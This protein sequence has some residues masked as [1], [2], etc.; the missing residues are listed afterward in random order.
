MNIVELIA[1]IFGVLSILFSIKKRIE[2]YP[3]G[4]ISIF[5]YI[6]ICWDYKI[7]AN[8]LIQIIFG[9]LSLQGW[10]FWNKNKKTDNT[11]EVNQIGLSAFLRSIL[12]ALILWPLIS[13]LLLRYSN[14]DVVMLDGFTTAF[15]LVG[16]WM[17]IYQFRYH[18]IFW[19]IVNSV[20]IVLY[21]SK[22][23]YFSAIFYMIAFF[24][25]VY[26]WKKWGQNPP[27]SESQT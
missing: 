3:I 8:M 22:Q 27:S 26:G 24:M 25:A 6:Y 1:A 13:I 4:L 10:Y 12:F 23:L 2:V 16:M 15:S 5:L 21:A 19:M 14:S 18:W 11:V 17:M 9:L 7:Y 20:S